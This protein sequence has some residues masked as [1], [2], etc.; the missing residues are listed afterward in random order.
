[1]EKIRIK[2]LNNHHLYRIFA[3]MIALFATKVCPNSVVEKE[4]P[5]REVFR[6]LEEVIGLSGND[7]RHLK[8]GQVVIRLLDTRIEREVA[9]FGAVF[10]GIP[11]REYLNRLPDY[12]LF[13]ESST[14]EEG[15]IFHQPPQPGD[16]AALFL[17]EIDIEAISECQIG[18][19][20]I[21]LSDSLIYRF[22]QQLDSNAE[23][24]AVRANQLYRQMLLDYV[25]AYRKG[26]NAA[27]LVYYDR[28]QPVRLVEEFHD[29]LQQT[30]LLYTYHPEFYAYLER[31]PEV[32]LSNI[33][34]FLFWAKEDI[35]AKR[36]VISL[37]HMTLYRPPEKGPADAIIAS[38]QFYA[39][40]YFEA[41]LGITG[42]A[43][44]P[45]IGEKGFYLL[46]LNRS[47]ID[48]LRHPRFG[49]IRKKI[50]GGVQKLLEQKLKRVKFFAETGT[51]EN[52][53]END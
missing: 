3:V 4:N 52:A 29:L 23:N 15:Q 30:A 26:G 35:G 42:L 20:D 9:V 38:K 27:L 46:Y 2:K 36:K 5:P 37:N 50:I 43:E 17:D 19:C 53:T 49:F 28:E 44:T 12:R 32:K 8:S 39:S 33:D 7:L 34:E 21:K 13:V 31:Y 41:A 18:D 24:F 16:V 1:M 22:Q 47:R 40:H 51:V 48:V 45:E 6:F 10:V 14:A 11:L 25:Q